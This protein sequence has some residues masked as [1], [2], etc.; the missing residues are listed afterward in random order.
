MRHLDLVLLSGED[1]E[2]AAVEGL[3][4]AIQVMTIHQAKGLEFEAVFVPGLVEGR[5]PTSGRSPRFELPPTVLEPLVR[6]RE[7]VIAE[8]RRLLYVAMTRAR[9]RLYLT[10]ASHY[11]GGRRWRDSRFLAEVRSAGPRTVLEREVAASQRPSPQPSRFRGDSPLGAPG[12]AEPVPGAPP[13]LRGEGDVVLSYS[14]IA[15]YRDCPRQYWYRYVQRLPVV[16]SAEAVHGVIL[17]EVLRRAGEARQSGENVTAALLSSLHAAVWTATAFPDPRRASA[18]A[19]PRR[20]AR[21]SAYHRC[22]V[23]IARRSGRGR[24][25]VTRTGS[26]P[27]A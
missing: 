6:G 16:Q 14:A 19:R 17:H 9:Q 26:G 24:A 20:R 10:R 13:S 11:E 25:R 5:L 23:Q 21:A 12:L 15:A 2:P 18:A 8:E 7:D 4:N 22:V 3:V 27:P 1:E